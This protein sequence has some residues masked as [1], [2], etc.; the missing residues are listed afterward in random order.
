MDDRS[1]VA[2][3]DFVLDVK[4]HWTTKVYPA[5]KAEY[6]QKADRAGAE[7]QTVAEVADLVAD[8]P[9]YRGYAWLERHLQR[10]KYSG[11]YGLVPYHAARRQA[12][13][14]RLDDLPP[15]QRAETDPE[16]AIPKYFT[17]IDIHQHPGGV[18]RDDIAGL[19]YER[20]ARSTTPLL[21]AK[22]KD[23]HGRF[24]DRVAA[25][26]GQARPA[27]I[28]D[29][30]CGFGKSTG[31]FWE[32]FRE[33]EIDGID[34]SA[35]CLKL[36]A[37]EAAAAQ[38]SRV[39]F[40]Q[41]DA[42][43]TDY[44]DG[45]FDLVTSTM[46]LHEMPPKAIGALLDEARRLLAPGGRMVHL[47]FWLLP[48]AFHRFIHYGHARRNN[49]PYMP[50]FAEMDVAAELS[51]RGFRNVSVEPFAE[52]EGVDTADSPTWRFPWTVIA[53]EA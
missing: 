19:V 20:G 6:R 1:F 23:L 53:A 47:D 40:R 33:A 49:E 29:M 37:A 24:T 41:M 31:P 32:M 30:G 48:D 16:F 42:R 18:W 17:A 43:A 7:P 35:P 44:P 8:S 52:A 39:R 51:A 45:S 13:L 2:A 26:F 22:H 14:A 9:L 25:A 28:L 4:R 27:R 21:G 15:E 50:P 38:A 46:L 36:A 12:L 5:L 3:Q 34:L 11:R 10:M